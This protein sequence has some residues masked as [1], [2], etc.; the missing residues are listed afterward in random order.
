VCHWRT[1]SLSSP[2][3]PGGRVTVPVKAAGLVSSHLV[4]RTEPGMIVGLARPEGDFV[5]PGPPPPRLLFLTAGSGITPLGHRGPDGP[6][7]VLVH[8][9]PTREDVIFG[10]EPR[11]LAA[12]LPNLR[13]HERHTRAE[14][15]LSPAGPPGLRPDWAER[16]THACGPAGMLDA[17]TRHRARHNAPLHVERFHHTWTNV[18]GKDRDLGHTLLRV[19]PEQHW[20]PV[21]VLQ[22]FYNVLLALFFGYGIELYDLEV[23]RVPSGDKAV[24]EVLTRLRAIGARVGRR[25]AKDH[26]LFPLLPGPGFAPVLLGDLTANLPRNVCSAY[27]RVLRP[28]LPDPHAA[29]PDPRPRPRISAASDEPDPGRRVPSRGEATYSAGSVMLPVK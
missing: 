12:R 19:G 13:L 9:A 6:G 21:H 15:R 7:V 2:P 17:V 5:L 11:D 4:R 18:L 28:A 27:R 1:Y 3:G 23:E 8:S 14:G 25:A 16:T 24:A 22:P 29:S 10:A 26:P 20:H